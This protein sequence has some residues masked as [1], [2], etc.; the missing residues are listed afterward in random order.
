MVEVSFIESVNQYF[1]LPKYLNVEIYELTFLT[2]DGG[3]V[4]L[5]GM[6]AEQQTTVEDH[7]KVDS[8][9][10]IILM[11]VATKPDAFKRR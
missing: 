9:M 10:Q 1:K 7:T 6:A 11:A 2:R 5:D 8:V 4:T 3:G